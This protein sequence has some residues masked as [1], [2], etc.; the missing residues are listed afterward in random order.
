MAIGTVP[1][2]D[3]VAAVDFMLANNPECPSWPQLPQAD[4][5]EGMYIQYSEGMPAAVVDVPGRRIYFDSESAPEA[6]AEFY[7][8]YLAGEV[9]FCAITSDYSRTFDLLLER[10]PHPGARFVKGQVTGPASFGLT[11]TDEATKPILYHSDLFEA[12]IKALALKG[13]WQVEQ[14]KKVAPE[15]TPVVFFD[16]PYL[17]Q[18]GSALISLPPEQVVA[19]LDECFSAIE[20]YTGIHV[21]GGTDWGLLT[22]T[23]ADILH[24]DAVDHLQEFFIYE[25]ELAAFMERGGMIAWGIVPTDERAL[26][27]NAA[28]LAGEIVRQAEKMAG[29][30]GADI[31]A[32]AVL[33]RSFISEACGTGT[34]EIALTERCFALAGEISDVLQAQM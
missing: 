13:R 7:E 17:T 20:G 31:D 22:T 23:K 25:R 2:K 16:E 19:G 10:L 12:V 6:M 27:R 34:L 24:F 30:C 28:D 15:L 4:F 26:D 8:H 32:E 14:Y 21:C 3:A 1:H 11:V 29:F 18:V 33:R 5:R 9:D